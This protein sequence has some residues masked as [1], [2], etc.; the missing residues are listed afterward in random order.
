[1]SPLGPSFV[2]LKAGLFFGDI[3]FAVP[4]ETS[5]DVAGPRGNGYSEEDF[6]TKD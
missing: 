3:R 1:M 4:R 2:P 5:R 6:F